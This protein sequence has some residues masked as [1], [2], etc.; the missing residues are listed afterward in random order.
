MFR[1][2]EVFEGS[3]DRVGGVGPYLMLSSLQVV[4]LPRVSACSHRPFRLRIKDEQ[5]FRAL[6]MMQL[7]G[8]IHQSFADLQVY[9]PPRYSV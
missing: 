1:H 4:S 8:K 9:L 6:D 7:H 5:A 2:V 3:H